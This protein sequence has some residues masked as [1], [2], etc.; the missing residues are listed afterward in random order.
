M[1]KF[2]HHQDQLPSVYSH[3]FNKNRIFHS[4]IAH[5]KD[6]LHSQSFGTSLGQECS[7]TL[8]S[9]GL[10]AIP[11]KSSQHTALVLQSFSLGMGTM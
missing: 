5:S 1:H 10:I 2:I 3:Y 6:A 8:D 9:I 4:Y 7:K 11:L